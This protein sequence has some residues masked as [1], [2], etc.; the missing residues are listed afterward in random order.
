MPI[1]PFSFVS[2]SLPKR[3][4]K[5]L[6]RAFP[7]LRLSQAQEATAK[8]LGYP[9]WYQCLRSGSN[10][11]PSP[12]DQMVDPATRALRHCHQANT[13]ADLG[14]PLASAD[15]WMRGWGLTGFPVLPPQEAIPLFYLWSNV[16][17]THRSVDFTE[18]ELAAFG[19]RNYSKY[20]DIDRPERICEGVILGPNGRY[21]YFA[22]EPRLAATRIPTYLGG[23]RD[24]FHIEDDGDLLA[25]MI[26]GVGDKFG[27]FKR[28]I[29]DLLNVV[30]YEWH[31][32]T[33]SPKTGI[34]CLPGLIDQALSRP[35][36]FIALSFRASLTDGEPQ[37]FDR[38]C[39]PALRGR[40]FAE[41]LRNKGSIDFTKVQWFCDVPAQ[42]VLSCSHEVF[43]ALLLPTQGNLP[44]TLPFMDAAMC[45]SPCAPIYSYPFKTAPMHVDEY[46]I[47]LERLAIYPLAYNFSSR[48]GGDDGDG[49]DGDG[50]D[51]DPSP[52]DPR[53]RSPYADTTSA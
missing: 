36:A 3:K 16:L 53:A 15:R 4:A 17:D 19:D 20:P 23:A 29:T 8:A 13:I 39:I 11:R 21:P 48:N 12:S 30:Q 34:T 7:F 50:P 5:Q 46:D 10:G 18:E 28:D 41:F 43:T 24:T 38:F 52:S 2:A 47:N 45:A 32:K 44:P 27:V 35:E 22:L 31:L 33:P 42:G 14:I 25:L 49:F 1:T 37:S 40:E 6:K 51:A 26:P 9:S